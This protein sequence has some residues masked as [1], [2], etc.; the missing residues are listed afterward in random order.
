MIKNYL[1]TG[2]RYTCAAD[3][4]RGVLEYLEHEKPQV[5][6]ARI[7]MHEFGVTI[8]VTESTPDGLVQRGV[9]SRLDVDE[10]LQLMDAT[11]YGSLIG[12]VSSASVEG[13]YFTI[14]IDAP[15]DFRVSVREKEVQWD[16]WEWTGSPLMRESR[17]QQ[18]VQMC[19]TVLDMALNCPGTIT[20]DMVRQ[21]LTMLMEHARYDVTGETQH[22]LSRLRVSASRYPS[23]QVSAYCDALVTTINDMG[24]LQ[25]QKEYAD[26]YLPA[27]YDSEEADRMLNKYYGSISYGDDMERRVTS[28]YRETLKKIE[29]ALQCL[30]CDLYYDLHDMGLFMHR[31]LYL[32]IPRRKYQMLLSALVL[33][34]HLINELRD[35]EPQNNMPRIV[36]TKERRRVLSALMEYCDRG[37]WQRGYTSEVMKEYLMLL[38]GVSP[39]HDYTDEEYDDAEKV[40]LLFEHGRGDRLRVTWQNMVGFFAE[41][42]MLNAAKGSPSLNRDFFGDENGYQNIDKGKSSCVSMPNGFREVTVRMKGLIE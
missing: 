28:I 23:P 5:V 4:C 11:G 29:D 9:V 26:A 2:V 25:R 21:Y 13:G 14:D 24:S 27:V 10:V 8:T 38:L 18:Q 1:I 40:W 12:R 32:D 35:A 34:H 41:H 42:G 17:S 30:P 22:A 19:I 6:L 31:L 33:R 36:M 3:E 7:M 20:D 37:D 15:A 16:S 39:S